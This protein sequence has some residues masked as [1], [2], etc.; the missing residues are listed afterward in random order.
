MGDFG[1]K[2]WTYGKQNQKRIV[3]SE[4]QMDWTKAYA[5]MMNKSEICL[6]T[7]FPYVS[8]RYFHGPGFVQKLWR[9]IVNK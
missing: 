2:Y 8:T 9:C 4:Q 1:E 6:R 5:R 7:T 3:C